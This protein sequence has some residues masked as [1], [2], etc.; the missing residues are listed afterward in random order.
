MNFLNY[1]QKINDEIRDCHTPQAVLAMTIG[2]HFTPTLIL[3]PQGG[4]DVIS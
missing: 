2:E 1:T 3:P 4:G